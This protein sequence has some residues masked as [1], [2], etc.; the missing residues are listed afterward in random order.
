MDAHHA[1]NA[2]VAGV[3]GS[4]VSLN[5]VRWAAYL[6]TAIHEP[7]V[8]ACAPRFPRGDGEAEHAHPSGRVVRWHEI[9]AHTTEHAVALVRSCA[10]EL[11]VTTEVTPEAAAP[12]L[13]ARSTHARIL[14]VGAQTA[15]DGRLV[16]QTTMEVARHA[17]CPVAIWRGRTG[18]RIPRWKPVTVGVDGTP[19]S[20]AALALGFELAEALSVPLTAVHCRPGNRIVPIGPAADHTAADDAVL[21]SALAPHRL[22]H[23]DVEVTEVTVPGVPATVLAETG[24]DSQL[25][26][27]GTHGRNSATAALF[28][29][30]S[31][32]LLHHS[33][34]PVVLCG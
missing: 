26:V 17:R 8:I 30:T 11:P 9:A 3:D 31:R 23:P 4:T 33:P 22:A 29:S 16:G 5:A 18:R 24:H 32:D 20:T 12:A 2:V 10:P 14:V 21:T 6:A 19:L 15:W 7:L 27:V 28:G 25:L 13:I 34:C 1:R